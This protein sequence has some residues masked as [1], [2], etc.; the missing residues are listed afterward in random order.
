MTDSAQTQTPPVSA[1]PDPLLQMIFGSVVTQMI[2]VAARLGLA[3]LLAEGPM[4]VDELAAATHTHTPSLYRLMRAL[5]SVGIFEETESRRFTL[6]PLAARLQSDAPFSLKGFAILL[7]SEFYYRSWANLLHSVQ[8]GESALELTYGMNLFEYLHQHPGDAAIFNEAMTSVSG[9]EAAAV[10]DAYDFSGCRTLVDV[11][12]GHGVLLSTILKANPSLQGILFDRPPVVAGAGPLL[13]QEG[14]ADRCQVVGGDFFTEVPAGADAYILKYVLHDWDAGRARKILENCRA[15]VTPG[16]RVLVVDAVIPAG[17]TPFIG[18]LRD[19]V[20]L[21]MTPG[22]VERTE[23]E[24]QELF[25]E[26]GFK[27]NRVIPTKSV[28]SIVEGIP[29]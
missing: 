18:K 16:G 21:S 24:F 7:G 8:T 9:R 20:M 27:L 29:V 25:S 2:A 6:T 11:G 13:Q 26:A 5:A 22:G 10:R 12:G 19:I 14:V 17:N 1:S 15:A 28:V 23:A 4:S 3:D